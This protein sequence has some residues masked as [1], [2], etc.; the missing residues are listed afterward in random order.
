MSKPTKLSKENR[1]AIQSARA[2]ARKAIA[3]IDGIAG[4]KQAT[5]KL[6]GFIEWADAKLGVKVVEETAAKAA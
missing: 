1:A 5:A 2:K 4:T 6:D 3:A